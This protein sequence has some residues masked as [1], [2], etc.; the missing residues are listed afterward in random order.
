MGEMADYYLEHEW[1]DDEWEDGCESS[2]V[3]DDFRDLL[4]H[5][6]DGTVLPVGEMKTRHMFNAMKMM[7]NHIADAHG[8]VPV[9]FNKQ[10]E[11]LHEKACG[12]MTDLR[13]MALL[14]CCFVV[15]IELRGDLPEKYRDPYAQIVAQ[16]QKTPCL[17]EA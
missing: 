12:D 17:S 2:Q 15:E 5:C 1:V 9:W 10:Y 4:W 13:E 7:F 3:V 6:T 14:V 11:G 8:G 16:L